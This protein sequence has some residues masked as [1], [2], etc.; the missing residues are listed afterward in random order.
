MEVFLNEGRD[1]D[2]DRP[3]R[4]GKGRSRLDQLEKK[5]T[6]K[7]SKIA[8]ITAD[9][10][11]NQ[12]KKLK[13]KMVQFWGKED[14]VACLKICIQWAKLLNDTETPAFYPQ[15]FFIITEIM[16]EFGN[17]VFDRMK[18]LS[19]QHQ[20]IPNWQNV[21][22]NEIDFRSTPDFV[23]QKTNNWFLKCA[24]IREV[25]PR[26]YLEL[27]LVSARRFLN[28]RMSVNDLDRLALMVRGI[29]EPLSASYTWMYLARWGE[30]IDPNAKNYLFSMIESMYKHWNYAA[31]YGNPY[32]EKEKYFKLF[33]PAIDW[34]F[35]W[36]GNNADE[37]L[38]KRAIKTYN[39]NT[40]KMV[41]LNSILLH[42]PTEYSWK[43]AEDIMEEF[44]HF[45]LDDR[46]QLLSSLG[47]ALIQ[48]KP[49][50]SELKLQ[51]L[52]YSWDQLSKTSNPILFMRVSIVLTEFAI[53][54]MRA[55]SVNT[56][57]SE[58][59]K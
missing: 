34:L 59:F 21:M 23:K 46:L 14:K 51:F 57:I 55:E 2:I 58:I 22:D 33:T 38:F 4:M 17:M 20:G 27:T 15:K 49:R 9:E 54:N 16:D 48:S 35:Y 1:R 36:A 50:R 30:S 37:K 56:F 12:F 6:E 28:K 47:K 7:G 40:K 53:K 18:K 8:S 32:L 24:C 25:L 31:E 10:F 5:K 44:K 52:N 3:I 41:Y 39:K 42:F 13:R 11:Q 19:L 43:Y 45:D 26:V 29:A